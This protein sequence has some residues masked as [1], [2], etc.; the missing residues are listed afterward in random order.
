MNLRSLV[1]DSALYTVVN[2]LN[3]GI[4]IILLPIYTFFLSPEQFGLVDYL[5]AIGAIV[6]VTV[7]LEVTQALARYL[8]EQRKASG[9]TSPLISAAILSMLVTFALFI[10]PTILFAQEISV[11]LFDSTENTHLIQLCALVYMFTGFVTL[12]NGILVA[13]LESKKSVIFSLINTVFNGTSTYFILVNT[14]LRVEALLLGQI[15]GA[16]VALVCFYKVVLGNV[17]FTFDHEWFTKM[18]SFSLPLIPSSVG[19][20]FALFTDRLMIKEF[21]DLESLG[22]YGIALR[23]A[24]IMTLITTGFRTAITP[25]IYVSYKNEDTKSKIINMFYLYLL[26]AVFIVVAILYF[27]NGIV[28]Y[29]SSPDYIGATEVIAILCIT[30]FISNCYVFFPGLSLANKTGMISVVNIFGM[31]LNFCLNLIFIPKYGIAGAANATMVAAVCTFIAHF[32]LA[33]KHYR[34]PIGLPRLMVILGA[35]LFSIYWIRAVI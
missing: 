19:V 11:L 33:Q 4:S 28:L 8:P 2:V 23:V 12:F 29:L 35:M 24:S 7:S 18:Y 3:K 14:E 25:L 20:I 22:V 15:I 1:K 30:V 31:V 21:L 5:A 10:I 26:S 6:A 32:V 9:D 16:F 17:R 27:Q 34:L 13:S